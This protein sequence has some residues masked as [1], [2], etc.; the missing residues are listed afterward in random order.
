MGKDASIIEPLVPVDLVIDH[1]V[2][3]DSYGSSDAFLKNLEMEFSR[4]HER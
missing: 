1:S 4:N 2:Q 3:I